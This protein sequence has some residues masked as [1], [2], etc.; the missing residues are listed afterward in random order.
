MDE[1]DVAVS[2]ADPA[3]HRVLASGTT[4]H[5]RDIAVGDPGGRLQ[6]RLPFGRGDHDDPTDGRGTAHRIDGPPEGRT[7]LD[8]HL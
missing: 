4:G 2:S 1:H 8:G 5:D 6:A 3:G 7:A